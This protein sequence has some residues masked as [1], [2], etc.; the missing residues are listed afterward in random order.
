MN[1]FGWADQKSPKSERV[2]Q[3][4]LLKVRVE[5]RRSALPLQRTVIWVLN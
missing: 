2:F 4:D 3:D 5:F 1:D